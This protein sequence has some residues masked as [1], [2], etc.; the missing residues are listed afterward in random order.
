M[1]NEINNKKTLDEILDEFDPAKHEPKK[2]ED[3]YLPIGT[4]VLLKGGKRKIMIMSYCIRPSTTEVYDK[5]GK[6]EVPQ[7]KIFDYGACFYPE[8]MIASD[9]LFAFDHDQ[10]K[11]ICY[12]GFDTDRQVALSYALNERMKLLK[13]TVDLHNENEAIAEKNEEKGQE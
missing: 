10:I 9:Q 11:E 6:V 1:E 12:R 8:G 2:P 3:K 4:V 13:E 5:N 7:E